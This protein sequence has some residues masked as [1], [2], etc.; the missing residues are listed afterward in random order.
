MRSDA[1]GKE[2]GHFKMGISQQG[3]YSQTRCH[4]LRQERAVAVSHQYIG[5]FTLAKACNECESFARMKR[6]VG[7]E[8]FRLT[9]E[10][11]S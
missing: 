4:Y 3:R 6:K 9:F 2:T 8:D 11:Q 1:F 5:M 7:R 10:C